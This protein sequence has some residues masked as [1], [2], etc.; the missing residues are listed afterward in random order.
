MKNILEVIATSVAD[1]K[2]INKSKADRI[3]LV[4]KLE[5]GGLSPTISAIVD[6]LNETN[7]PINVMVRPHYQNFI[8]NESCFKEI[9]GYI[10]K[11][12]KLEKKPSGI[13]FGSLTED[14]NINEE[15]LKE[16]IIHKGDLNL[17]FHRAFDKIKDYKKSIEVLNK[18]PEVSVLLT[19]GT[20][21]KA[22]EAI[23]E[24]NEIVSNAKHLKVLVGSGVS[25]DNLE[26]LNNEINTNQFHIGT[27]VRIDKSIDK[28]I[29]ISLINKAKEI[30]R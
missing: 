28:N 15:Q 3:E 21:P 18:Y 11:L 25:L 5:K 22:I 1:V 27:A 4:F 2:E 7:I 24:L 19:S 14:G 20:K 12:N 8:Y 16:I 10:R 30:I 29:D 26:Q 23:K 6:S 13:V 9:L 17:T